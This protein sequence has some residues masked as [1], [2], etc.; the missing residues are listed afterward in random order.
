MQYLTQIGE[1]IFEPKVKQ[2]CWINFND[3]KSIL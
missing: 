1:G 3:P 2:H